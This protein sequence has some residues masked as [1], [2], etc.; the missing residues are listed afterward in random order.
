MRDIKLEISHFSSVIN[1]RN[2]ETVNCV[3]FVLVNFCYRNSD[4]TL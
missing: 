4:L 1:N 3:I 2:E